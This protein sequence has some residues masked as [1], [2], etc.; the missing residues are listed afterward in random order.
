LWGQ[1]FSLPNA[2]R[3]FGANASHS[4]TAKKTAA[5]APMRRTGSIDITA[6]TA[7]RAPLEPAA[8]LLCRQS[9]FVFN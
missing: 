7:T 8:V 5:N 4:A 9:H 3:R 2:H 1:R 6:L